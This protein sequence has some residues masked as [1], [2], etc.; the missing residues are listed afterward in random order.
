MC[1]NNL[2]TTCVND[3]DCGGGN[4]CFRTCTDVEPLRCGSGCP[5]GFVCAS[6][7]RCRDHGCNSDSDCDAGA[8]CKA[9]TSNNF[10]ESFP[11]TVA[12]MHVM[13]TDSKGKIKAEV[14]PGT[15]TVSI[16]RGLEY[17]IQ[18]LENVVIESKK[19]TKG[20]PVLLKRV[21]DTTGYMSADFH[22]H[23]GRSLDSSAPLEARVRSFAGEGLEV[24][25]STDHD[26]NTDFLPAIGKMKLQPFIASII[27]TE[28]TT[29]VPRAPY[30][31]NSWGHFN[32]WPTIFDPDQRR[33]GS[34]EDENVSLN[35]ILDRLRATSNILCIGGKENGRSCPPS[36]CPGG[37]CIDV[38]EQVVQLNH[39]RAGVSGVV[40]IGMFNN[41]GY[42]PSKAI[43][44]CNKY[45]VL[46]NSSQCAGGTNDGT[47]CTSDAQ[48]TGG[49]KCGCGGASIPSSAN[50]CNDILRDRNVIPQATR[51]TAAGCGSGFENPNGTRNVDVDLME[52]DN[53]GGTGSFGSLRRVRRDWLSLLNQGVMVGKSGS[54]HPLWG[55]GV[56]DS[57][58]IV[59]E[60]PGFSRT[61]VGAGDLPSTGTIDIKSFNQ[62]AMAGNMVATAGPY[63]EFTIDQGGSPVKMGETLSATGSVNLNISVQAAPWVPVDEVRIVKNGCVVQCINTTTTP[64]VAANPSDPYGDT[65]VLRF[66]ATV[67]QSVSGDSYFLV[68]ASPN[69]P[70]PGTNPTVD[71]VVNSVAEGNYPFGF[72][73]PIFVDA[74][75]GGYTGI[76]L[77][78]GSAEPTCPALPAA[79]SAGAAVASVAP[80]T[81]YAAEPASTPKGLLA[82]LLG[83]LASPA[84]AAH[85]DG[86]VPENEDERMRQH[87][88]KIRKSSEEYYPWHLLVIPTP[89][90][91]DIRSVPSTEPGK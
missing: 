80:A 21:V 19:T 53:G 63:I 78:A 64:A 11:G 7:G 89:R 85:D 35:V 23:S 33:G 9:D 2:D 67:T 82:R 39:P 40:S 3:S 68:E 75:S 52:I 22:I 83:L 88:K 10:P 69:L 24:M 44:G 51:C 79:C 1:S 48:C 18:K 27:G 54:Q 31:A 47:S 90:P 42:D 12:Q 14:R 37:A 73:N 36:S 13:Y 46:C 84:A 71:P 38:G 61:Y 76:T 16:S 55:T 34:V 66:D 65:G 87:E 45:P 6:D 30:L 56:S 58:R 32:G 70:A 62:Q 49:G 74:N 41:I 77:A 86:P 91:E 43:N 5:G 28:V 4:T 15:Y 29:S 59:A 50:G 57:H 81:L 8:L 72:T 60:L 25:V 20:S 26:I 17:T